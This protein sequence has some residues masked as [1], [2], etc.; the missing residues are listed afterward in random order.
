MDTHK[1]LMISVIVLAIIHLLL[2]V[3]VLYKHKSMS[4][5]QMKLFLYISILACLVIATL[6]GY[7]LYM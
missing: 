1:I 6:A 7:C 2:S 3:V 4:E 5:Y